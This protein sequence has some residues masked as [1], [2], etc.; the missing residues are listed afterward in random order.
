MQSHQIQEDF[1]FPFSP[2]DFCSTSGI[3]TACQ[4]PKEFRV[5]GRD[6]TIAEA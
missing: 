2:F 1:F 3:A 5:R 4:E 6:V